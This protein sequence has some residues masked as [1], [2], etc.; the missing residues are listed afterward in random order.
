MNE[1][2]GFTQEP[3]KEKRDGQRSAHRSWLSQLMLLLVALITMLQIEE[4]GVFR[5]AIK[6]LFVAAEQ[7][8]PDEVEEVCSEY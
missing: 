2:A 7:P 5:G 3:D 6:G 1:S 4:S 8:P